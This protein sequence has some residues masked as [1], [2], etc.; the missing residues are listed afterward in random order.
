[1]SPPGLPWLT[2]PAPRGWEIKE[3]RQGSAGGAGTE[4]SMTVRGSFRSNL[5]R[6]K[7]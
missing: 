5:F 6:D 3:P 7:S 2:A 4:R 1:M